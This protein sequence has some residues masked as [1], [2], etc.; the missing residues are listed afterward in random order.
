MLRKFAAVLLATTLIAGSAYAA[1]PSGTIGS[2]PAAP[3]AAGSAAGNGAAVKQTVQPAK[4]VAATKT[5]TPTKTAKRE[6]KHPRKHA[7]KHVARGKSGKIM[8]SQHVKAP[9]AH[10]GHKIAHS[11]KPGK[12]N[13]TNKSAA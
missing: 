8:V 11:M 7:R 6:V 9:N 3:V 2:T 5:V 13:K 10:R 1:Q 12:L 4:T